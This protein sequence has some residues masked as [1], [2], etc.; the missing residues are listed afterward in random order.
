[1]ITFFIPGIAR[2]GGSKKAF[3][4]RNR[5]G[6][7]V[8]RQ[9]GSPVIVITDDAK[10]NK[11]WKQQCA[12]FA[13]QAYQGPPLTGPLK[14][15]FEFFRTRPKVHFRSNG[16]I[17]EAAKQFRPI[18]KPDV[19]KLIRAAEDALTGICWVDDSQIVDQKGGKWFSDTPGCKVTI[20]EIR[21]EQP[22]EY[23]YLKD[24]PSLFDAKQ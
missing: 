19:T 8:T 3:A 12:V 9:N 13:K 24:E 14:V 18:S 16:D 4:I 6:A 17:K 5:S 21:Y 23:F 2:P 10:G 15:R 20:E 7:I 22:M 11:E 1:M